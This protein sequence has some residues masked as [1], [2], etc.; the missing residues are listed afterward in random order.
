MREMNQATLSKDFWRSGQRRQKKVQLDAS[1]DDCV[2]GSSAFFGVVGVVLC[3][4][5]FRM[6]RSCGPPPHT[7]LFGC[8]R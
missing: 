5:E 2:V 6:L 7:K 3:S 8:R 1:V 4:C